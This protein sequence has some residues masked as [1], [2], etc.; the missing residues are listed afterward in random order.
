MYPIFYSVTHFSKVT[1]FSQCDSFFQIWPIFYSVIHFYSVDNFAKLDPVFHSM[2]ISLQR[3]PFFKRC[4]HILQC[5]IFPNVTHFPKCDP[6]LRDWPIFSNVTHFSQLVW[7][8][9]QCNSLFAV[10]PI[11]YS[12]TFFPNVT[13]FYSLTL[14]VPCSFIEL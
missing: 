1:P 8:I 13:H 12:V 3:Y 5:D 14:S 7:P 2:A 11:V 6:V 10:W 9:F 4:I